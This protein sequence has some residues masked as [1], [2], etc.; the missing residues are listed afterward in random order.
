MIQGTASG[1]GKSVLTAAFCRAFARRGYRV[2]PFKSQ[3]MA[4]NAFV[5]AE[6]GEIGRAQAAQAEAA[7]VAPSVDMNPILLKPESDRRAQVI[8]Q[9][10]AAGSADFGEYERMKPALLPIVAA[11]L[12]RLRGTADLVIIEGAGSPAEI[13]LNRHEIVNMRVARMAGA[14]V[15]LVGDI[16]RGGVF[17]AFVGTLALLAPKD[18]ARVRGFIIN[19]FRGDAAL[20][21]SGIE[22]LTART[23][24]PVLGIVPYLDRW[25]IPAEDSLDLD[26]ETSGAPAGEPAVIDIA[27]VRLPRIANFDDFEPL[28]REPGVRV[29]FVQGP[30]ELGA[31]DLIVLPGSKSTMAD[32]QWLRASGSA[33]AI[34]A[35]AAQG[36]PI[37]GICGGYQM[38]G[39]ALYDPEG[40]E[41]D[42]A[43][44]RG[45]GLLPVQTTFERSKTT[46]QVA[47]RAREGP[48]LFGAAAGIR[49]SAYE[50]H[51]GRTLPCVDT[52]LRCGEPPF[53]IVERLGRPADDL[54]GTTSATG[55]VQG[56]YLHGLFGNASVRRAVLTHLAG[57]DGKTA[58]PR[59][60]TPSPTDPYD[61]LADL[62]EDA[63]DV[64]AVARLAGLID[65]RG[66]HPLEARNDG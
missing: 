45:L 7:R 48:G 50:I 41:S 23:G 64:L 44:A 16:D 4:L 47:A 33:E 18:R 14:P 22:M 57:R 19:K 1:A 43:H 46:A 11:S 9:G 12:A 29:R 63:V 56:T 62:I 65:R 6:G 17:A 24:V 36:R 34:T 58:D 52:A 13:N 66:G 42:T 40:V 10:V 49:L 31:A 53:A 5:T 55:T 30:A 15:V 26:T 37:L 54:E 59:W 2:K 8:V 38:L 32:L 35:A 20:L 28:A 51:A 61:R 60:G 27:V 25:L 21:R 3:N 39:L